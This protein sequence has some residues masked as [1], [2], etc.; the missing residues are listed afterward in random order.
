MHEASLM[1]DLIR[2]IVTVAHEQQATKV[3][4]VHVTLGA[5]SHM[6]P[7]HLRT[8]FTYAIRGTIVEGARL[9]IAVR[10]ETDQSLAQEILLDRIEVEA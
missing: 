5:W 6:S 2:K 8:H 7:E 10:P 9:E 3:L 4:G 1:T